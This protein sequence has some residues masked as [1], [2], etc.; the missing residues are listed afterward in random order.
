MTFISTLSLKSLRQ[1]IAKIN[2]KHRQIAYA[3]FYLVGVI[4]FTVII[5]EAGHTI[6]ALALGVPFTEIEFGFYGINPSVTIP[7]RFAGAPLTIQHYAGGFM[8][9]IILL[10]I[11]LFWFRR[12]RNKPNFLNW[13]TGLITI[14]AFGLQ[15]VQGYI[16]GRFHAIYIM[17][18]N[19]LFDVKDGL[20]Y[21]GIA[22]M[23]IVHLVLCPIYK[24]KKTRTNRA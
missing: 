8:A 4:V 3:C 16:E 18:A 2:T 24:F 23:W 22:L 20:V 9:A 10:P 5:H 1:R 15:L 21:I 11:Y 12:Y 13:A 17:R 19:S 6:A 14:T 7:D